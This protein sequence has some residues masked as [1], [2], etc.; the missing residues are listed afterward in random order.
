MKERRDDHVA[1]QDLRQ[2]CDSKKNAEDFSSASEQA[3]L[4]DSGLRLANAWI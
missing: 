3:I 2:I 4:P 1:K